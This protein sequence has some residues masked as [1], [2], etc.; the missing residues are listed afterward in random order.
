MRRPPATVQGVA[1]FSCEDVEMNDSAQSTFDLFDGDGDVRARLRK[2]DWSR[3]SLGEPATWPGELRTIVNMMLHSK[4]PMFL[5][6]GSGLGFLYNDAY[7]PILGD[8]HPAAMGARFE[9]VWQ[10]IWDI[11]LPIVENAMGGKPAFYEDLPLII[12]RKG[13]PEA[14]W[15]TFSYSPLHLADGNVAGMCCTVVETTLQ[16]E[17]RQAWEFEL[18][19]SDKLRELMRPAKT[20]AAS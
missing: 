12:D 14:A 8:K 6:W 4:F 10:E 5:A 19:L 13:Y 18:D 2:V 3:S 17:A 7:A 1:F 20:W 11:I 9:D 16:V 15:F